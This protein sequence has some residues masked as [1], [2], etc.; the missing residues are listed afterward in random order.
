VCSVFRQAA[1]RNIDTSDLD[2]VDLGLLVEESEKDLASELS[3]FPELV[4]ASAQ[5]MEPH[6]IV[7]YLREVANRLHAYYNAHNVLGAA[8]DLRAARLLLLDATR[9]VIA[10]GL[11][12]LGV[13]APESM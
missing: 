7:Y 5:K 12:V 4:A 11:E 10:N 3:R 8:E 2:G 6:H 9:Q 13:S 1:E